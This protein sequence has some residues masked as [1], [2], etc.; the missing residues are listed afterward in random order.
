MIRP[1]H[2]AIRGS[3]Q[4]SVAKGVNDSVLT[5]EQTEVDHIR[6]VLGHVGGSIEHAAQCLAIAKGTLYTKIRYY[7]INYRLPEEASSKGLPYCEREIPR[8]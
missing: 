5:L 7:G 1:E 2:L 4:G 8:A 3:A 6:R